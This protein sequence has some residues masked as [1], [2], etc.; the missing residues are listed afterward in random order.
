MC[1]IDAAGGS[2]G[3]PRACNVWDSSLSQDIGHLIV[4]I[5][6]KDFMQERKN[7][8]AAGIIPTQMAFLALEMTAHRGIDPNPPITALAG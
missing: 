2:C 6:N 8:N 1:M 5:C 7:V 4:I 3:D